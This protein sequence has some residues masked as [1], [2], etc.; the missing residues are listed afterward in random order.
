MSC[1]L[2]MIDSIENEKIQ[3]HEPSSSEEHDHGSG[4]YLLNREGDQHIFVTKSSIWSQLYLLP[5]LL[6]K[7]RWRHLEKCMASIMG[8][9]LLTR[10][11]KRG[12]T[13]CT[14][15]TIPHNVFSPTTHT[16]HSF[17]NPSRPIGENRR[18]IRSKRRRI[19][20]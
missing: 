10:F 16:R 20:P 7:G 13:Y 11:A 18:S 3:R 6:T 14:E 8:S 19:F 1:F 5:L 12:P 17:M 9:R 4:V 15:E 2:I